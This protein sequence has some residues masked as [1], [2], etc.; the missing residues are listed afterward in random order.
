MERSLFDTIREHAAGRAVVIITHRLAGIRFAD[1][2]YV[3][4]QGRI[5]E[6]GTHEQLISGAGTYRDPYLLQAPLSR[7]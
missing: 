5:V 3:L 6:H 2:I 1:R 4:N 7:H